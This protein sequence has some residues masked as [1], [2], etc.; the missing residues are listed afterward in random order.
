MY[1]GK[2]SGHG[3]GSLGAARIGMNPVSRWPGDL[4]RT[5]AGTDRTG[6]RRRGGERRGRDGKGRGRI[7]KLTWLRG[8]GAAAAG[9]SARRP[10]AAAIGQSGGEPTRRSRARRV[11]SGIRR[12]APLCRAGPV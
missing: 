7:D 8:G 9:K 4:E 10:G 2:R 6:A 3:R 11:V 1:A 12:F 5:D